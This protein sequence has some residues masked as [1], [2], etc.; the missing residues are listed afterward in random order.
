MVR[1]TGKYFEK[2]QPKKFQIID[3]VLFNEKLHLLLNSF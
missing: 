2:G 1:A 3:E